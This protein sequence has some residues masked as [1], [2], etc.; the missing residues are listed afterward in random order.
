VGAAVIWT[1]RRLLMWGGTTSRESAA[2]LVTPSRGLRY[3]PRVDRWA[4]LPPAPVPGRFEPVAA[5]TGRALI[6]VGGYV[7]NAPPASG[8][9]VFSDGAAFMPAA[10]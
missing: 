2:R 1:G 8:T 6:V 7:V 10:P 9:R 4:T 3:D 5:W